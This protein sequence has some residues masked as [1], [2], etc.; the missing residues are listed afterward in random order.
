MRLSASSVITPARVSVDL[1]VLNALDEEYGWYF[2]NEFDATS[3]SPG[4]PRQ[5]RVTLR[6][7]F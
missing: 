1:G 6:W 7:E 5:F 2:G 4:T 3:Y